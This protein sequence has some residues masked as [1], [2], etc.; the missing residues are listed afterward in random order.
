MENPA[1]VCCVTLALGLASG[2]R[3]RRRLAVE[4]DASTSWL[5]SASG[6]GYSF[7]SSGSSCKSLRAVNRHRLLVQGGHLGNSGWASPLTP[8]LQKTQGCSKQQ[9]P[10]R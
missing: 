2:Q 8:L 7:L 3:D 4:V 10:K 6:A 9:V 1:A 5:G